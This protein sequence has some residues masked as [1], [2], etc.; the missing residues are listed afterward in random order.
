MPSYA[1]TS[2]FWQFVDH[3]QSLIAGVLALVAAIAAV[4]L[5]IWNERRKAKRELASLRR[6]LGVEVRQ[7]TWNACRAHVQLKALIVEHLSPIP[8]IFVEDKAKLPPPQIYPN[9]VVNIGELGDCAANI[10]LFYNRIGTTREAAERL[11]RLR[12]KDDLPPGEVAWAVEGLI[13]ISEVGIEILP[14]LKTGIATE[15]GP[16][17]EVINRV[18]SELEDWTP[19]RAAFGVS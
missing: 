19:R 18:Q 15:D 3:W 12:L 9:A 2:F 4:L 10:V 14:Q 6:A 17:A 5:A 13:R 7:Y 11:L 16:D 8:A 1:V